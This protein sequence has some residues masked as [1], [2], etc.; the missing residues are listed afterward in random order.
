MT[1]ALDVTHETVYRYGARVDLAQHLAHLRPRDW[2][3]QAVSEAAI[4]V[5]PEPQHWTQGRDAFGNPR[6]AFA[7]YAP[8]ESLQVVARS[9]VTLAG[10]A[11]PAA[12]DDAGASCAAVADSCRYR[13]G[14]PYVAASEFGFASP[15]VPLLPALHD[16]AARSLAPTRPVRAAAGEL[17]QRIHDDFAYD[18]NATEVH[19]PLE[20]VLAQRRG[21]CQDFAHLMIGALRAHGLPA[22]YVS[23]Y[24]L[25]Q[26]PPGQP[27]LVGADASHAWVSVWCPPLGWVEFDPTNALL[28]GEGASHVTLAVGRDYGDV[29]PLRGVIRGGGA[30]EL[31]VRVTV[32]PAASGD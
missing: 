28:P 20:E 14:Q 6:D 1:V 15:F 16:Y 25:T 7:L 3:G 23:G 29:M 12:I 17:M 10:A 2:P 26:P 8:H 5:T 13:A 9:R 31:E 27:R 24:L 18:G 32:A 30:H 4:V 19:T 22:R 21:V 11:A